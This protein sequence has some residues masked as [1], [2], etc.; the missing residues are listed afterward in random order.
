MGGQDDVTVDFHAV[1]LEAVGE[2]FGQFDKG[3]GSI[4][5]KRCR[6]PIVAIRCSRLHPNALGDGGQHR[7]LAEPDRARA[8]D[9]PLT[10]DD[11]PAP[12]F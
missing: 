10:G 11:D 5:G 1:T 2:L 9:L 7:Q 8:A 6:C 4:A 12:G 3:M